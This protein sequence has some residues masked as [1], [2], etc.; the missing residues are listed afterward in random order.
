MTVRNNVAPGNIFCSEIQGSDSDYAFVY[1]HLCD[2]VDFGLFPDPIYSCTTTADCVDGEVCIAAPNGCQFP[3]CA[4]VVEPSNCGHTFNCGATA[5]C[6]P[7]PPPQPSCQSED[8]TSDIAS[9]GS[10]TC[11]A[12]PLFKLLKTQLRFMSPHLAGSGALVVL[13]S[14]FKK[15]VF[16]QHI[17]NLACSCLYPS[18]VIDL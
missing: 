12:I 16:E 17:M 3:V 10:T 1:N 7:T 11:N 2:L 6:T 5:T 13:I 8:P 4:V 14:C 15:Q 9:P 18:A